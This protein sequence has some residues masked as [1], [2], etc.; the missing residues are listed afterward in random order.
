MYIRV[1]K[2]VSGPVSWALLLVA[3]LAFILSLF[4]GF[5][6]PLGLSMVCL[7]TLAAVFI[8]WRSRSSAHPSLTEELRKPVVL[9]SREPI[10][11]KR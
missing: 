9:P 10:D 5:F 1:S 11:P 4:H 8:A 2:A 6:G 7:G 3:M